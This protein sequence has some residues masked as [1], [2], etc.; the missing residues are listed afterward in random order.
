VKA[1]GIAAAELDQHFWIS[2]ETPLTRAVRKLHNEWLR[3]NN[4]YAAALGREREVP[5]PPDRTRLQGG[6]AF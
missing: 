6:V 4:S 2:H 1:V 3:S 5:R